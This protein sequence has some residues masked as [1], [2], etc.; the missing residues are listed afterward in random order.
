MQFCE[1]FGKVEVGLEVYFQNLELG[2]S[3]ISST[4]D[5][6]RHE[7]SNSQICAYETSAIAMPSISSRSPL[8]ENEKK[9]RQ[10]CD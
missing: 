10:A 8:D 6:H 5:Q 4:V 7:G 1:R 3:F 2:S 9:P